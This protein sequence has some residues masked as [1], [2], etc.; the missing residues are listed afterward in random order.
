M[1]LLPDFLEAVEI[2]SA[3]TCLDNPSILRVFGVSR[4]CPR[5]CKSE[6]T[7]F[8]SITFCS[9]TWPSFKDGDSRISR[10]KRFLQAFR[11]LSSTLSE[12]LTLQDTPSAADCMAKV[13][14]TSAAV[15][16]VRPFLR[17][18]KAHH[19]MIPALNRITEVLGSR[20]HQ[21]MGRLSRYRSLAWLFFQ[22][23][24][25][26]DEILKTCIQFLESRARTLKKKY[27]DKETVAFFSNLDL[28]VLYC[29]G[30]V[31]LS[32]SE[33]LESSEI[34]R[35]GKSLIPRLQPILMDF[36]DEGR[37][38]A[39][40][41]NEDDRRNAPDISTQLFITGVIFDVLTGGPTTQRTGNFDAL[42]FRPT[43][44]E[45]D[46]WLAGNGSKTVNPS[47]PFWNLRPDDGQDLYSFAG[48]I[49]TQ[50][51]SMLAATMA[52]I[53]QGEAEIRP[54]GVAI[55]MSH[56]N[57]DVYFDPGMVSKM[58]SFRE[59]LSFEL[60]EDTD[61]ESLALDTYELSCRLKQEIKLDTR[62]GT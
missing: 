32:F 6:I 8:S 1:E 25:T 49:I 37:R 36:G 11:S 51:L 39:N 17:F 18:K 46:S 24:C 7:D 58:Y 43:Y 26:T 59:L 20:P 5:G 13:I 9:P 44:S 3:Q 47:R 29:S 55:R 14:L 2:L 33:P 27:E 28:Q 23:L 10:I 40:V 45:V 38:F 62:G 57:G 22:M 34:W 54:E 41:G 16:P 35:L 61:L 53:L 12:Y 31:L 56:G 4:A 21:Y 42:R 50:H 60:A 15:V 48:S 19:D 30:F 52:T